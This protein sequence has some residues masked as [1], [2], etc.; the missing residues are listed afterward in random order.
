[1]NKDLE[2]NGA[3][4]VEHKGTQRRSKKAVSRE[5]WNNHLL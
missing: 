1:M 3:L 5:V 4:I 2:M